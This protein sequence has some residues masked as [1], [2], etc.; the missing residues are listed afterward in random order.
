M[1]SKAFC[2]HINDARVLLEELVQETRR[3][4]EMF[5]GQQAEIKIG[6]E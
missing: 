6:S 1:P 2:R 5:Y 4:Q 3:R